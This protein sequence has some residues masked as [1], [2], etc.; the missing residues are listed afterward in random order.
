M[1]MQGKQILPTATET[2]PKLGV[3]T[4]FQEIVKQQ[5]LF[6]TVKYKAMYGVFFQTGALLSLK[7]KHGYPKF[8][9][10]GYQEHLIISASSA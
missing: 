1:T 8:F 9:L 3:T 2:P 5:L 10:F 7:K 6:K 4:Y